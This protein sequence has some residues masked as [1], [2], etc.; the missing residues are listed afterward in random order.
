MLSKIRKVWSVFSPCHTDETNG[1]FDKTDTQ[2]IRLIILRVVCFLIKQPVEVSSF[3]SLTSPSVCFNLHFGK[4]PLLS[5]RC[6]PTRLSTQ[7]HIASVVFC[8][9]LTGLAECG[10]DSPD[11]SLPVGT[12]SLC[13]WAR[14][15]LAAWRGVIVFMPTAA[16]LPLGSATVCQAGLVSDDV[17]LMYRCQLGFGVTDESGLIN[18]EPQVLNHPCSPLFSLLCDLKKV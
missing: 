7:H 12:C 9:T 3:E 1:V 14:L 8:L 10:G 4:V 2:I 5:L 15:G 13:R 18:C 11:S 6:Q 17:L 16:K